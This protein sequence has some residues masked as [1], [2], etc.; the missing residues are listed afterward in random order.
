MLIRMDSA[1]GVDVTFLQSFVRVL[2]WFLV[3]VLTIVN[4]LSIVAVSYAEPR[5]RTV[6]LERV[7]PEKE[8][9]LVYGT[10][11]RLSNPA[12]F[13][14]TLTSLI[15]Q[16]ADVVFVNL[17]TMK[18]RVIQKGEVVLELPVATKGR[19]GSWWETPAGLYRIETKEVDRFSHMGHVHMP[20]AMQFSGNFFI[21]GWPTHPDGSPVSS[22]FSGGCIRLKDEDA[23]KLYEHVSIGTPILVYEK[24]FAPDTARFSPEPPSV[25]ATAFLLADIDS[26]S[27]LAAHNETKVLPI[28]SLTK[29]VTALVV[30]EHINLDAFL[31]VPNDV[32][33]FTSVARLTPGE[34]IRA[35]DALQLLLRESSNEAAKTFEAFFGTQRAV[36]LMNAKAESIGLSHTVFTDMSGAD[37]GNISTAD[38]LFALARYIVVNR[39]FVFDLT[40]GRITNA[41]Y[42]DSAFPDIRTL[43]EFADDVHFI[44]GKN[45]QTSVAHETGLSVFNDMFATTPRRIVT[46]VLRSDNRKHD[47]EVLREFAHM[48][49][50]WHDENI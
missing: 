8:S 38:D 47:Q 21:H 16:K 35:Y 14:Q 1:D 40:A 42:G 41:A 46:I 20:Y 36:A 30:V 18:V 10:D 2:P 39:A 50:L 33:V 27:V 24:G 13:R 5:E 9:T 7:T 25:S 26:G 11:A 31:V 4:V 22:T 17:S 37:V 32:H 15:A 28:A 34:K 6:L 12:F 45:G 49:E 19:D 48:F 43:N 23:K 29:L 44:G 3:G